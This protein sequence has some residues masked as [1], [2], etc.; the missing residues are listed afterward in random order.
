M[1]SGQSLSLPKAQGDQG[2]NPTS[3]LSHHP[4]GGMCAIPVVRTPCVCAWQ[5][6]DGDPSDAYGATGRQQDR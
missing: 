4:A 5:V 2:L 1:A 3:W 6:I